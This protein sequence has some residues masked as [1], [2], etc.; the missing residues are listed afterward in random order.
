MSTPTRKGEKMPE[1]TSI[2]NLM[3]YAYAMESEAARRY[4]EFADTMEVH[5]N[6][7]VAELFRKLARIESRHSEHVLEAMH[8]T[9]Q[10]APPA[11]GYQWEG[12]SAPESSQPEELHYLMQPYHALQIALHNEKRALEFFRKLARTAPA[13]LREAAREM[14]ADEAEHVALIEAWLLRTPKPDA[15]WADD[16]DPPVWND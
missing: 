14:E 3:A 6:T 1:I 11:G 4:S 8:W 7:E 13:E 2:E 16:P 5:N 15:N 12:A 10:P 9:T